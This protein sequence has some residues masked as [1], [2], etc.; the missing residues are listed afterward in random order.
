M[1]V[2]Q[3]KLQGLRNWV[4]EEF[5]REQHYATRTGDTHGVNLLQ[6]V[7]SKLD[8]EYGTKYEK[9][10]SQVKQE[11]VEEMDLFEEDQK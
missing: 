5:F 4:H 6:A 8:H 9:T 3:E 11:P 1:T 7:L 10:A 2:S